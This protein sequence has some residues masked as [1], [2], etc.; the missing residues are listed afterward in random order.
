MHK[1]GFRFGQDSALR[2]CVCNAPP[3]K[4]TFGTPTPK[5]PSPKPKPMGFLKI[6]KSFENRAKTYSQPGLPKETAS[7]L[8]SGYSCWVLR[9]FF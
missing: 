3:L 7:I 1:A 8:D 4:D 9:G 6:Q 2:K 5:S